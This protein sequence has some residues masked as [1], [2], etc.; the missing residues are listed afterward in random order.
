MLPLAI[1]LFLIGYTIA[2]A[3]KRNLGVQYM[4]QADGSI[5]PFDLDGKPAKTYRLMDVITCGEPGPAAGGQ[6]AGQPPGP[7]FSQPALVADPA[8]K[9]APK[10]APKPAAKSPWGQLQPVPLPPPPIPVPMPGGLRPGGIGVLKDAGRGVRM[11]ACSWFGV[12]C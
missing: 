9:P 10:P 7:G 3:G 8:L 1:W 6:P 5:K 4:P 11:T 12:W 2:I